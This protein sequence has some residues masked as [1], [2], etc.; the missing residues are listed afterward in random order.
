MVST[1]R[2][3]ASREFILERFLRGV[4]EG[5]HAVGARPELARDLLVRHGGLA[6]PG[7]AD[8]ALS[9]YR[10]ERLERVPYLSPADLEPLIAAGA[11]EAAQPTTVEPDRLLDQTLLRRLEA[12]G[13]VAA[14]YR[15]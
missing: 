10:G 13:F 15:A 11:T 9:A 12:S 6:A 2:Y 3:L 1:R 7:Q 8:A 4:L 14:L 5:I